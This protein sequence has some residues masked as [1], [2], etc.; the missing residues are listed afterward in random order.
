MNFAFGERFALAIFKLGIA[1]L[2]QVGDIA[3]GVRSG[4]L[5]RI[6]RLKISIARRG[7]CRRRE[8]F[9]GS[10]ILRSRILRSR[11]SKA[12]RLNVAE[13]DRLIAGEPLHYAELG[14]SIGG[15][16]TVITGVELAERR[17]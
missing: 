4:V 3:G 6:G 14:E 8:R 13:L 9:D 15:P 5:D 10:R 11:A 2:S 12:R 7:L 1:R 17:Q 16:V